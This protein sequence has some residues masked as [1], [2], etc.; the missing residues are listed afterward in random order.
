MMKHWNAKWLTDQDFL[1]MPKLN[2]YHKELQTTTLPKHKTALQHH[3]WYARKKFNLF[4]EDLKGGDV[5]LD[6]TADDYY[7]LYLNGQFVA[8]GPAQND[9]GHYYYNRLHVKPFLRQGHNVIAVHVYYQG[10]MNRAW[11]SADYRQGFIAELYN[12]ERCLLASDESWKVKR[13]YSN[14]PGNITGYNTQFTEH[15][16][17]RVSDNGWTLMNYDDSD[18]L[19]ASILTDPDYTFQL[20]PTPVVSVYQKYPQCVEKLNPGHFLID[21]GEEL[22]GQFMMKANGKEGDE[23]VVRYGEELLE[24]GRAVRYKMRCNCLY[25]DKW[26][27]SGREDVFETYDYKGFRYVEVIGNGEAVDPKSFHAIVRHYPFHEDNCLF[28]CSNEKMNQIFNICKNGVKYGSQEHFVDCPTREKGQYLGDNTV[29]GHSHML[30][31]G[32]GSLYRKA[33]EQFAWS[34]KV[35]QGLMAVVPGHYMQE[36]ADYSLQWP[37]QLLAYYRY[38]GDLTFVKEMY[39]YAE[40]LIQYFQKYAREDGLLHQVTDKW[41]LV[42]WP[43]HFRDGYD[44]KLSKPVGA[45]CHNVLNAFYIG[46]HQT[47]SQIRKLLGIHKEDL[48][49][50]LKQSY[51]DVFYDSKNRWFIDAEGSEHHSLHSNVLPLFFHLAPH[52]AIPSIVRLIRTKRLACGVY[53][54][55]FVL[56]ALAQIGEYE[57]L[58][59]LMTSDDEHSWGKM[60]KQGATTCFEVWG[61][62]QKWNT[63]L[64]H[65][66]ASAPIPMLIEAI[67]GLTPAEPGWTKISFKPNLPEEWTRCRLQLMVPTGKIVL[68]Y[69]NGVWEEH[70]PPGVEIIRS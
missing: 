21:F 31:T 26:I 60:L 4:A 39:P 65:P 24:G 52:D 47:L 35:C 53:F 67:F 16:D 19:N 18:W 44:F 32:D 51:M 48:V 13:T 27:L 14:L 62:E 33:I 2:L 64:C 61:K 55:Y 58:Y 15:I 25:Q 40:K 69:A 8:Q 57:L 1:H 54:S 22:T 56:K 63:S 5:W 12:N 34:A 17:A 9:A 29:I 20:Q 11:N 45:G 28:H 42:D 43:E 50:S 70:F 6:I 36:I 3:H 30:L 37:M 49:P 7:K 68:T 59:E 66:W 41:N 10:L 46:C 38:T 23:I